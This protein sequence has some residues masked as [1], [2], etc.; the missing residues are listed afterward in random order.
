MA[1]ITCAETGSLA[2]PH[3]QDPRAA[4]MPHAGPMPL[5]EAVL[6]ALTAIG[7]VSFQVFLPALPAI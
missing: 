1:V 5:H 6:V 7:P 3:A 4:A 2:A